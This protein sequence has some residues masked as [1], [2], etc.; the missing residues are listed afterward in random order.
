MKTNVLRGTTL[1][2]L[3]VLLCSFDVPKNWFAAGNEPD[4][5]RMGTDPTVTMNGRHAATIQSIEPEID[6]FGT[7]MQ[8]CLPSEYAGKRV[9]MSGYMKSQDVAGWAG[10]WFR[11]D[12]QG[13]RSLAFDNMHGRAVRGTTGWKKYEIVLDVPQQATN[14]AYGALLDGTEEENVAHLQE[15]MQIGAAFAAKMCAKEGAFGYG[16]PIVGRTEL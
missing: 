8:Q 7:L 2:A 1:V 13:A 9:R 11:V 4:S 3:V 16:T 6:G 12:G 10:F 5:Y 15:A 14:L